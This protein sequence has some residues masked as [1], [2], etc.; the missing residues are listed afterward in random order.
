MNSSIVDRK[1]G[2]INLMEARAVYTENILRDRLGGVPQR[3]TYR[4]EGEE[5]LDIRTV[6]VKEEVKKK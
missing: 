3:T 2:S 5:L 6:L 4:P 1:P